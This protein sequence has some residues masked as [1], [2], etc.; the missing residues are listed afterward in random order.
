MLPLALS[1]QS[2]PTT[3]TNHKPHNTEDF[4]ATRYS[5]L[6]MWMDGTVAYS[7]VKEVQQGIRFNC[8]V[9]ICGLQYYILVHNCS[10]ASNLP[11]LCE[12]DDPVDMFSGKPA[13]GIQLPPISL[14]YSHQSAQFLITCPHGDLVHAFLACDASS[15]C[16][17]T[18]STLTYDLSDAPS[19]TSCPATSMTL[20]PPSY[21]CV[22][23]GGRVPYTWVCDHR[24]DCSDDSDEKFC[25]HPLCG[26][27]KP[28]QCGNTP[29]VGEN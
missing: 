5:Q 11:L 4:H 6:H 28:L 2:S 3:T 25:R 15:K 12:F 10:K 8:G 16:W 7:G 27:I 24:Q 17:A 13:V 18:Q 19:N 20:L 22:M 14:N 9:Y 29:Q 23:G 26:G 1:K 21:E